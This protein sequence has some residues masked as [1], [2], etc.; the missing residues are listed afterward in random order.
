MKTLI[1]YNVESCNQQDAWGNTPLHYAT[2]NNDI[3]CIKML[4]EAMPD[5]VY[6][7]NSQGMIPMDMTVR[8]DILLLFEKENY[9]IGQSEESKSPATTNRESSHHAFGR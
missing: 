7:Q 8:K 3:S 4:M 6:I 9:T 5:S 2:E 1:E